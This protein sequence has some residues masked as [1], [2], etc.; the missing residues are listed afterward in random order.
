MKIIH[1]I[2]LFICLIIVAIGCTEDNPE[3]LAYFFRDDSG[4]IPTIEGNEDNSWEKGSVSDIDGN[5]YSTVKIGNKWWMTE[6]LRTSRYSDGLSLEK[7][8]YLDQ[9]YGEDARFYF[10]YDDDEYYTDSYGY[11]YT[12]RAAM[13]NSGSSN[14]NPSLVRGICPE[15]WHIPSDA[16][17]IEMEMELGLSES[18][19]NSTY[20]YSYN[21]EFMN[22][23]LDPDVFNASYT[24]YRTSYEFNDLYTSGYF[25]TSTQS[26]FSTNAYYR[27]IGTYFDYVDRSTA[28]PTNAYS[29]RCVKDGFQT[30]VLEN[31]PANYLIYDGVQY[32]ITDC[33]IENWGMIDETNYDSEVYFLTDGMY[34]YV[35][36]DTLSGFSGDGK[37]IGF[38]GVI[39]EQSF[40]ENNTYWYN[41]SSEYVAGN[42]YFGNLYTMEESIFTYYTDYSWA[43]ITKS[44]NVGEYEFTFSGTD[45]NNI[46]FEGYFKGFPELL[47]YSWN[48]KSLK[49]ELKRTDL[50]QLQK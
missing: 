37:L 5:V 17:W 50:K 1:K 9:Y 20:R 30:S 3:E 18:E 38:W 29:V 35:D 4:N 48:F 16:E 46:N 23:F 10:V 21:E 7:G 25:W 13:A 2:I 36:S 34:Y 45:E 12:W 8:D 32:T 24:G 44:S 27:E 40:M 43:E 11:Y 41:T 39:S 15:G 26:Q 19:A 14:T 33:V 47:D 42:F 6:N 49:T 31:T 22:Y 28:G